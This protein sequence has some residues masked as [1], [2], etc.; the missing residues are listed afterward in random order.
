MCSFL[1]FWFGSSLTVYGFRAQGTTFATLG[2]KLRQE[3][4]SDYVVNWSNGNIFRCIALLSIL[5]CENEF[6]GDAY[7]NHKA[8]TKENIS[9]YMQALTFEK[10]QLFLLKISTDILASKKYSTRILS[11]SLFAPPIILRLMEDMKRGSRDWV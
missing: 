9:A 11:W 2:E 3:K 8:L 1:P 4:G 5:W 7:D 10:V 6:P